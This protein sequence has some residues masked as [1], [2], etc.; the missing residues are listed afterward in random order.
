MTTL[1]TRDVPYA[2]CGVNMMGLLCAPAGAAGTPGVLLVPDAYGFT[3]DAQETAMRLAMLGYS[4]VVADMWGGRH[5]ATSED[6]IGPLI[7]SVASDREAWM[8][9]LGAAVDAA[10]AQPE[11]EP[12]SLAGLGYC[13]GG[14]GVLEYARTGGTLAAA[15]AVHPGLDLLGSDWSSGRP[16]RVLACVGSEDP[17]ANEQMRDSLASGLTSS[18]CD[19]ELQLY[20][21]TKH[22]FTS[23]AAL[24]TSMPDVVAFHPRNAARAWD[25]TVRFLAELR[26]D[27]SPPPRERP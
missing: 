13:V 9:R 22:A 11:I 17:L 14:S 26:D 3:H 20:S 12:R 8:G 16:T 24:S 27:T 15:I 1:I 5:I 19:W 25:A 21:G 4:V 2:Y 7:G 10:C 23:K 6:Q 18:G